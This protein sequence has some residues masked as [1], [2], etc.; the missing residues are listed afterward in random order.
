MNWDPLADFI[1]AEDPA[2]VALLQGVAAKDLA[3]VERECAIRLPRS[4]RGFALMMGTDSDGCYLFG[5][6]RNQKFDDLVA[7]LPPRTYPGQ[8]YFKIGSAQDPS[9]ISPADYFLDLTRSD[10]VDA[11]L[12]MFED[13]AD[14]GP[15]GFRREY[16]RDM[17][18]TFGE[19]ATISIFTFLVLDRAPEHARVV[20]GALSPAERQAANAAATERLRRMNF[21]PVLPSNARVSSFR[22]GQLG[23]L[24]T[25]R[26]ELR[27][28]TIHLSGDKGPSLRVVV[29]QLRDHFPDAAMRGPG[30]PLGS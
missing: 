5:P 30:G 29:D 7:Q 22:R 23:A 1:Q 18:V 19:Q 21:D 14:L 10:G 6:H 3:R 24:V 27:C 13:A 25:V 11:P 17:Y 16:V 26:E 9:E 20:I 2:F 8:H 4:Y 15:E 12:V 28:V